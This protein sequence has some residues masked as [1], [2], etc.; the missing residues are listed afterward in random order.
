MRKP[1]KKKYNKQWTK[2]S[3]D[4]FKSK[5]WREIRY[6]ALRNTAGICDCCGARASDGVRTHVDH[7]K[8]RSKYPKL[9]LDLDNL[10]VLCE[11]CNL[12]KSNYYND[13]WRVKM[14]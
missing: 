9:S 11:D 14:G 7:I 10:Q 13:D 5:A 12:G 6:E 2:M 3:K 1:K 4:F 8:P